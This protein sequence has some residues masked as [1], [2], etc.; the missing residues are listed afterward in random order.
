[1]C[2]GGGGGGVGLKVCVS[3]YV[4]YE[5]RLF[6]FPMEN[7]FIVIFFLAVDSFLLLLFFSLYFM[8]TCPFLSC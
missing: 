7:Y 8:N 1:M 6:F 4:S 5:C 3:L 2:L